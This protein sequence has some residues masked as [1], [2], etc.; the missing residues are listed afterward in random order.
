MKQT[1]NKPL[2][3]TLMLITF[4]DIG[5]F[6]MPM[7]IYTPLF[8]HTSFL[9]GFS[10]QAIS[11]M[12]GILIA[13]YGIAQLFGGPIFG[14]LSDQYG[15]KKVLSFALL[16]ATF[17]SILAGFSLTISS[18][19][20][21]YISRLLIGF[22]S[23]TISVVL[24]VTADKSNDA[25]RAKNL[26]YV[27]MGAAIGAII[28]PIIGGHLVK[29]YNISWLS[30]ATPFYCMS[31]L[32]FITLLLLFKLLSTDKPARE[33]SRIHIFTGFQNTVLAFRY[34]KLL[35]YLV[36]MGLFYQ[37]GTESFYL[38]A[39]I[40]AVKKFHFLS[41]MISNYFI[42]QG[43]VSVFACLFINKYLSKH[44]SSSKIYLANLLLII[45]SF[46]ILLLA[47]S[48][49]SF[50]L[51]FL[52]LGIGG[53]LCWIH[54]N[55]LFSQAVDETKQ[56]LIFGVS[57]ALWSLGG[58]IGSLLVGLIAAIHYQASVL[59]LIIAEIFSLIMILLVIKIMGQT[60][61]N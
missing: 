20:L 53:T 7:P 8:L 27:V 43:V 30:Y 54:T 46:I 22:S 6:F 17:G 1:L 36:L 10:H 44:F 3:F 39:P 9:Q 15:R 16:L 18:L 29:A 11:I 47:N 38:A 35:R 14:E 28:G 19:S 25:D 56:G 58:I 23:G 61:K 55:N 51:P 33:K 2:L 42:L 49:L 12:L 41:A 48:R 13:C 37:I 31:I 57:Q 52:G 32:Y 24:A 45:I 4:L 21:V 60:D 50:Y 5:N 40:I 59:L 26:G 34:S